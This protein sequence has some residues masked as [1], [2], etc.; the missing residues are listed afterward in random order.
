MTNEQKR[1]VCVRELIFGKEFLSEYESELNEL[2]ESSA[3][4]QIVNDIAASTSEEIE[5]SSDWDTP[6]F[7]NFKKCTINQTFFNEKLKARFSAYRDIVASVKQRGNTSL[8]AAISTYYALR[9]LMLSETTETTPDTAKTETT[10]TPSPNAPKE[11]SDCAPRKKWKKRSTDHRCDDGHYV[12][13]KNEQ[14]ID[15]WLYYHNICHAYEP[16]V[17]DNRNGKKYRPD[18]YLPQYKLLIEMWG[19]DNQGYILRSKRKIEAYRANN[20]NL[21]Q[22]TLEE[23]KNLDDFLTE[24]LLVYR[25]TL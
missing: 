7:Q 21:L 1:N 8:T 13:S 3:V 20:F 23:I 15:N 5:F 10:I 4:M 2:F 12:R 14:L 16:L 24:S 18:F 11:R 6:E 9:Y 22:M 25:N 19:Y 17:I